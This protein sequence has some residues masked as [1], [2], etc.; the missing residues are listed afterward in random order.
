MSAPLSIGDFSRASHLTVKTLRHYHRIGL[1]EPAAIDPRTGY[2]HYTT[3]QLVVARV[4]RRL[5]ELEMPLPEI[6][7][8]L[9][10]PDPSARRGPI[11]AHRA[12]LGADLDRTQRALDALDDLLGPPGPDEDAEVTLRRVPAVSA[13]AI[14][15]TV[16]AADGVT[17][18]QGALGELYATLA[19]CGAEPA[20]PA[21]GIYGDELF[22]RHRGEVTVFVP[23]NAEPPRV[24]RVRPRTIP[25]GEFAI[26]THAGAPEDVGRAYAALATYVARHQLAVDGPI[27]EYYPVGRRDTADPELWRTEIAWPV[28]LTVESDAVSSGQ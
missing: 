9:A 14:T 26:I 23:G 8:V 22:T 15:E 19:A 11:A 17:W 28:F 4:I 5:R 20:G 6:R 3:Q 24:G 25:A 18:L 1:L 13:A 2:R 12:R 21:G 27:R 16:D 7:A 10:A